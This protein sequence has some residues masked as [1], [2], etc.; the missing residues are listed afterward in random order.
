MKKDASIIW[1]TWSFKVLKNGVDIR[2]DNDVKVTVKWDDVIWTVYTIANKV[3]AG[4]F[5][6]LTD[7]ESYIK[8]TL[9][10][11]S[12]YDVLLTGNMILSITQKE[13]TNVD[14]SNWFAT[15]LDRNWLD[16]WIATWSI[17]SSSLTFGV[18][19][20]NL[21]IPAEDTLVL[22][23]KLDANRLSKSDVKALVQELTYGY[24]DEDGNNPDKY[25]T[26]TW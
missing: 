18:A 6:L 5:D 10:N 9:T 20:K 19:W 16:L 8:L 26:S 12:E 14:W 4:N 11:D 21:V 23:I 25:L 13:W 7:N 17:P 15:L 24:K 2:D 3:P 22:R 1:E